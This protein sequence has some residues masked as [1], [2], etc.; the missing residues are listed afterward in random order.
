MEGE[1][2]QILSELRAGRDGAEA[3]LFEAVY[4]ELRR[5]A[6]ACM[7]GEQ[8]QHTLQPTALVHEAYLRL[9]GKDGAAF[10]DRKHFLSA[11]ARAMRHVLVD[12]GRARRA[13]KRGGAGARVTLNEDLHGDTDSVERVLAV[14]D[15]LEKLEREDAVLGR[16]VE[17]RYFGGLQFDEIAGVMEISERSVYRLWDRARAW[18]F[19]EMSS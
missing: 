4:G 2:T 12:H 11:A 10:A 19:V 18:L 1:V 14:H 15:A 9:L 8:K 16:L 7:R 13:L 6:S 17:L 5:I 3:R